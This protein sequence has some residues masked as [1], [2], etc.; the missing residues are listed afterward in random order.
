MIG[1]KISR[2]TESFSMKVRLYAKNMFS[3]I[4][5]TNF[6]VLMYGIR[7]LEQYQGRLLFAVKLS[8]TGVT[9][10]LY[11]FVLSFSVTVSILSPYA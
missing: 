4:F 5:V 2:K 1:P 3:A 11:N 8:T 6:K 10:L 7:L 9:Q